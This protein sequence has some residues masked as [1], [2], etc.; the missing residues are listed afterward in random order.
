MPNNHAVIVSSA[1]IRPE[2]AALRAEL[3]IKGAKSGSRAFVG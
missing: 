3:V 2:M 1:Q